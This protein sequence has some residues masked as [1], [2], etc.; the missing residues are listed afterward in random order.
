MH[1]D[2]VYNSLRSELLNSSYLLHFQYIF[3]LV[4]VMASELCAGVIVAIFGK[5]VSPL[6]RRL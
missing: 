3:F 1:M 5:Q 4:V 2:M 6:C